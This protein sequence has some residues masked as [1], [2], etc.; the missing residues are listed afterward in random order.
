M[1]RISIAE[2]DTQRRL[3]VEG[4]L[5]ASFASELRTA[6]EKAKSDLDHRQ[7]VIDLNNLTAISQ[8]GENLLL[9]LMNEGVT[10]HCHGVFT[11]QVLAQLAR[12]VGRRLR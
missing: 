7:L 11:E 2:E 10:L 6:C 9:E 3:T 8:A 1:L 12:R 4:Q 5:V